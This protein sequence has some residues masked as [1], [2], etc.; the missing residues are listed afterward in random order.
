MAEMSRAI[1]PVTALCTLLVAGGC[2]ST[3]PF[4]SPD[5]AVPA[6]A[7]IFSGTLP[8]ADCSGIRT[9][10]T[11][12]T[13]IPGRNSEGTFSLVEHYLGTR[14]G[15]RAFR[16]QGRWVTLRGTA[17]DPAAIVYQLV[18][19]EGGRIVNLKRTDDDAVRLL[20]TDQSELPSDLRHTLRRPG[21]ALLGGYHEVEASLP[22]VRQAAD[23]AV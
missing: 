8:C 11:L 10:I 7:G 22:D 9:D 18:T 16:S 5:S 23:Y 20:A 1:V 4:D 3:P 15:D 2:R 21:A 12:L 14:T 17:A 13:V 19:D 6:I